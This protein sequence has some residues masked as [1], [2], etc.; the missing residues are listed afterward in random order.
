MCCVCW[1]VF[2]C[3][4]SLSLSL[5]LSRLSCDLCFRLR[6]SVFGLLCSAS[7][8]G[9]GLWGRGVVGCGSWVIGC[10]LWVVGCGS[11]VVG[12][13]LWLVNYKQQ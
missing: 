13:G 5:S 1:V 10:G 8:V 7:V 9:C 4:L 6:S 2:C 3:V 11:W 12:C